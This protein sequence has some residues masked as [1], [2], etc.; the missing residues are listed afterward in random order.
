[1]RL[2]W[3]GSNNSI[4]PAKESI[5]AAS[6]KRAMVS[7]FQGYIL[8]KILYSLF[9]NGKL[10]QPLRT[11]LSM[12]LF[13]CE[14]TVKMAKGN[15]GVLELTTQ[16]ET[17]IGVVRRN[18]IGILFPNTDDRGAKFC[19]VKLFKKWLCGLFCD[20][21]DHLTISFNSY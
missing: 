1:M 21:W 3:N 13:V 16:R 9:A 2:K 7:Q 6:R 14:R 5:S 19:I 18:V 15:P 10:R 8:P 4:V 20:H 12:A 17:D 11:L